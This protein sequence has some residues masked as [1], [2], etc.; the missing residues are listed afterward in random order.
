MN[1]I[2][3]RKK[4]KRKHPIKDKERNQRDVKQSTL[5]QDIAQLGISH[6]EHGRTGHDSVQFE[7]GNGLGTTVGYYE[8]VFG[9]AD[10][11]EDVYEEEH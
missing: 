7:E 1:Q 4:D 6:N 11:G 8:S 10:G 2:P 5:T 3:I 9:V